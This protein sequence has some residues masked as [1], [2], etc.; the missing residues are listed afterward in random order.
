M[1]KVIIS[2]GILC[3]AAAVIVTIVFAVNCGNRAQPEAVRRYMLGIIDEALLTA[4]EESLDS[5]EYDM[6]TYP[7][8]LHFQNSIS[9]NTLRDIIMQ[10]DIVDR[11]DHTRSVSPLTVL[12][13]DEQ[14][15]G[16]TDHFYCTYQER[17]WHV[18]IGSTYTQLIDDYVRE[19]DEGGKGYG[20]R[21]EA[22]VSD[23]GGLETANPSPTQ[24]DASETVSANVTDPSSVEPKV[25]EEYPSNFQD[26]MD[27]NTKI[28]TRKEVVMELG[29]SVTLHADLDGT[30]DLLFILIRSINAK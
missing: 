27:E 29:D 21:L 12:Y 14:E 18:G 23:Q 6:V 11:T 13:V 5:M 19:I 22:H 4:T 9:L 30:E 24:R 25:F 16:Y 17:Y 15:I 1:K 8:G 10:A 3:V 7:R 2:A 28:I 20:M 26:Y